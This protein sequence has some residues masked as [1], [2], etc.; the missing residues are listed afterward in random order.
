MGDLKKVSIK[1]RG[2]EY[3]V[4][5]TEDEEYIQ[6]L[7]YYLEEKLDKTMTANDSLDTLTAA[8][9]VSLNLTDDLFKAVKCI[10]RIA[11]K[12]GVKVDVP[13][14]CEIE[15]IQSGRLPLQD[16]ENS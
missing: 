6:K 10:D 16:S 4:S 7:A 1:I 2:R 11:G 15:K 14:F 8:I 5:C 3:R 13:E 12:A 9:L